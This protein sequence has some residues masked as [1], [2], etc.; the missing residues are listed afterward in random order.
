MTFD[1]A[2]VK[3]RSRDLWAKGDYVKLALQLEPA[4]RELVDA[5]A[6]SAG[7]EVLDV[8]AGN[9]NVAVLAAREGAAVTA[10]DLTPE[11]LEL[12]S[13]RAR[14]EGLEVEWVE[15]DAEALPFEDG[16]FDAVLTAFGAMLTPQPAVAARELVRVCRPGG[17]VGMANW[18]AEGFNAELFS[19]MRSYGPPMPPEQPIAT[20]E[21]GREERVRDRFEELG[22][23]V[24]FERREIVWESESL[25]DAWTFQGQA[26]GPAAALRESLPPERLE[27]MRRDF[28]ELVE[29]WNR[30]SDGSV[31]VS[32]E[33]L[34]VVA[35]RP[36]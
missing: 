33:Y 35:R 18:T 24:R 13:M 16:S 8:A 19:L 4:A 21:W 12:G 29:R 9:G 34:L 1:P 5:C 3:A 36:G 17:T 20:E 30:A 27:S 2:E 32:S 28:L 10:L 6:V 23:T 11:M 26:G 22:V 14:S 25:E 7:Q 15:G 31:S